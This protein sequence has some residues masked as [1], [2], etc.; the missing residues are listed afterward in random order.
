M[1]IRGRTMPQTWMERE[2]EQYER[3]PDFVAEGLAIGLIEE[4]LEMMEDENISQAEMA[5]LMGV[6]PAYLSRILNAPPNLTLRSI[7]Q[8]ALALNTR[9]HV[10]LRPKCP[11]HGS[12]AGA[13]AAKLARSVASSGASAGVV[14]RGVGA[15]SASTDLGAALRGDQIR[16]N[17]RGAAA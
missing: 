3:S 12:M 15:S 5:R 2:L 10:S 13:E 14:S 9:P 1:R 8:I 16:D 7:A 6:S 17:A 11:I 4:M